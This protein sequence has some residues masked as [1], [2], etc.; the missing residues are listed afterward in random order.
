MPSALVA[1]AIETIVRV[2]GHNPVHP[3]SINGHGETT[4]LYGMAVD[5]ASSL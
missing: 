2:L 5:F 3:V 4:A 1:K